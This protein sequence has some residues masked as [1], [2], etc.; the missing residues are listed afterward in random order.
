MKFFTKV[1]RST[2]I[3]L[4]GRAGVVFF[5][6]IATGL[7]TRFLGP[8]G[9]GNY[10]FLTSF[11]MIFVTLSDWGTG[12]ISVRE[13]SKEAKIQPLIF[14]NILLI[15]LILC[16]VFFLIANCLAFYFSVFS[17]LLLAVF[18]ASFLIIFLSVRSSINTVFQTKLLF[19]KQVLSDLFQAGLF[20]LAL[21]IF[22]PLRPNLANVFLLLSFSALLAMILAVFLVRKTASFQF[23]F[24]SKLF[25]KIFRESL[26]LGAFLIIFSVYNRIDTLILQAFQGPEAVGYYG[27]AYK[28]HDNLVLVAAYL[29][30]S[31]FPILS[32]ASRNKANEIYKKTFDL[33]FA[34]GLVV[35][36]GVFV[37]APLIIGI[38]GG[39]NFSPS[40][41]LLRILVLATAIAYLN[42]LTGYFLIALGKQKISL[43]IA[44][45]ALFFNVFLNL[46]FIPLFSS[47]AAALI[48]ILTEG[49]VLLLTSYYLGRKFG[50]IPGFS[51]IT[52]IKELIKTKGKIY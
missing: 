27:L 44:V 12:M 31:L 10:V 6:L 5:T 16:L 46:I 14:G 21:F 29:M 3:Q 26:P 7:L 48:T 49:L 52:T 9:Y 42:H 32:S 18:L 41:L 23:S 28:V 4:F 17:P 39:E 19:E 30:N 2:F 35:V 43:I 20:L 34:A 24:S 45:F 8:E 22:L 47:L 38:L 40:I 33:L 36:G 11:I 1:A 50:F 13:A 51:F 15:R 37:F 25:Y